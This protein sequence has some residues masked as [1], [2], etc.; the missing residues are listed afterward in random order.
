MFLV[1]Q[2]PGAG[3]SGGQ[4]AWEWV[5]EAELGARGQP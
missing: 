3:W 5:G 1:T 4:E 2:N